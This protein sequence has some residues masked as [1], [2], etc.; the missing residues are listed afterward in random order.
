MQIQRTDST[1]GLEQFS[2]G[3]PVGNQS[4]GLFSWEQAVRVLRKNGS[5]ALLVAGAM[6]LI[7]I[8]AVLLMRDVYQPTARL[9]IDPLSSG[10]KTLHEIDDA[11]PAES[12]DYLETQAQILQSD[13]LAISVIRAL[14]LDRNPEFV[15]KRDIAKLGMAPETVSAST[16][17]SANDNY[18]R[19]QFDLANRTALE[20]IALR[21]FHKHLSVIPI[22]NSRLI[23]VSF[24]APDPVLA[25]L[26]T[27]SL[28]TQFIDHNY[29]SRYTS[30][31][32][33]SAWLATQLGDLRQ[34]V[35]KSNQAVADYQKRFGLIE[36]DD[37]DV[38]L[39]QLMSEVNRRLSDAQ[40]E[41]I[42]AE[43]YVRMIDLGQAES[44]PALRDDQLYQGLMGRYVDVRTQ[45]AQARTVYGDE[46]ANVKKLEG[47]SNELA[48]QLQAERTR[49]VRRTRTAFEAGR[50]R[51]KM[52]FRSREKL[53]AQMG[54]A[55]SH[56]VAYKLLK[57]E[58]AA[59]AELYNT[60]QGRL[61]EA[62]IYA[63][64]KSGNIH[65]VDLAAKL[66]NASAPNRLGLI[67]LGTAF[68]GM[69]GLVLAFARE[70]LVN[71]VRSPG[72]I[73]AWTGLATIAVVPR[74]AR[75]PEFTG[76]FLP[77]IM[78][79][80]STRREPSESDRLPKIFYPQTLSAE[81]ESIRGLRTALTY[82]KRGTL[83][84]VFLITSASS[85]EG[86]TTVAIN[87][88]AILAQQGRTCLLECDVRRPVIAKVFGIED[89]VL[90]RNPTDGSI[91]IADILNGVRD[92]A[93]LSVVLSETLRQALGNLITSKQIE[94]L[95][96][97]LRKEFAYVIIDSPP[98][99]PVADARFLSTIADAVILVA[100][101]GFTTQRAFIRCTE[102]LGEV[103]APVVGTVLND[104]DF[105]SPDYHFYNYGF[106]RNTAGDRQYHSLAALED[107]HGF[108]PKDEVKSKGAHG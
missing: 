14:H 89:R 13:A 73:E 12:Q 72:E 92:V 21:S 104:I 4:G 32:E 67:A 60:L 51:E 71:T 64:L 66:P 98:V 27:N 57:S 38:P 91:A 65:V 52:M 43:A 80:W 107:G 31:M 61:K 34:K 5:L 9:E 8:V 70:S 1:D 30:T 63:G 93:G 95:V 103:R 79:R 35:E 42:E 94:N 50:A 44:I 40:A 33:A 20:S 45:L 16:P 90:T 76:T 62:G 41:R 49:M 87:L 68:S 96:S 55:S 37:H 18:L 25:Q 99:I 84:S 83:Q 17:S 75:E 46:N 77:R 59:N 105:A 100:R 69:V 106:S 108:S 36:A 2:S 81:A 23:E 88:A 11:S 82:S 56:M 3:L 47:E 22:R 101:Y 7:I 85:G 102:L 39:G 29:R 54:D 26:V 78:N 6:T 28:V 15:S 74:I 97:I 53:L 24:T 86:K 10:I 19:E 48:A 58:A